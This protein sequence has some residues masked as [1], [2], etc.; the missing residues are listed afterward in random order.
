MAEISPEVAAKYEIIVDGL[1]EVLGGDILK[2]I[3][4]D[5]KH[6]KCYWGA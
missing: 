4:A 6:P 5:G 3:L 1:Q 2:Q